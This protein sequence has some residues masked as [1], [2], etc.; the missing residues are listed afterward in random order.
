MSENLYVCSID[1]SRFRGVQG[2]GDRRL[3][4]RILATKAA[5]ID[6][7]DSYFA[8]SDPPARPLADV[9]EEIVVGKF[10]PASP[11]W[12]YEWAAVMIA[13]ALG[14]SLNVEAL[15]EAK[16]LLARE[17]DALIIALRQRRKIS[18]AAWPTIGEVLKRGPLLDV[19]LDSKHRLGTGYLTATESINAF[20]AATR[21]GWD[22]DDC[23]ARLRLKL[24][25]PEISRAAVAE[26]VTW[27]DAA[28]R[29][30]RALFVHR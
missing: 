29:R 6:E 19:P 9:I 11:R 25:W 26:Y 13:N 23:V 12:Q 27:L 4:K 15:Q 20:A 17:V 7:Y 30:R 1:L 16:P 28:A 5:D 14:T 10:A 22:D 18:A 2:S 24:R 8:D 3:L 21:S